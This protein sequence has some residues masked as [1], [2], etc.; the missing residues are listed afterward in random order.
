MNMFLKWIMF[1]GGN[2]LYGI[3]TEI[4]FESME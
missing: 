4:L 3:D 1:K 2:G